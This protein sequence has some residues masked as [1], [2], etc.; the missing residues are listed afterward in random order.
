MN[1]EY[2]PGSLCVYHGYSLMGPFLRT[3]YNLDLEAE[4]PH[5][6]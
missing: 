4:A 2:N 3:T 1:V 6:R 5:A